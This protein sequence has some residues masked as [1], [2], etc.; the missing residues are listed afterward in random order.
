L[1]GLDRSY[2]DPTPLDGASDDNK[3]HSDIGHSAEIGTT[4]KRNWAGLKYR[5]TLTVFKTQC[6]ELNLPRRVK[7]GAV[8]CPINLVSPQRTAQPRCVY[9]KSGKRAKT[10]A[11][12]IA[13]S[14]RV[15]TVIARSADRALENPL[16]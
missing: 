1:Y 11:H 5:W 6:N 9:K 8:Y 15:A 16:T 12:Q 14:A 2:F 13:S 7:T 3:C 10:H 4:G